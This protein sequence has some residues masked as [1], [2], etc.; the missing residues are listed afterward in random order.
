MIL[1]GLS[2]ACVEP[3][4]GSSMDPSDLGADMRLDPDMSEVADEDMTGNPADLGD[5]D[6]GDL[7]REIGSVEILAPTVPFAL[8]TTEQVAFSLSLQVRDTEGLLVENYEPEVS[9]LD[10]LVAEVTSED[11]GEYT[12]LA[13]SPG[14]TKL[15]ITV[16]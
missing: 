16:G 13:I 11:D 1:L 3:P 5:L 14:T 6:E 15:I 7:G 10:T 12:L 8:E 2:S 9:V 4:S